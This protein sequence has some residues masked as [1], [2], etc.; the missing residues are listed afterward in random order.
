MAQNGSYK[1]LGPRPGSKYRQYF[2]KGRGVRAQTLYRATLEPDALTPEEVAADRDVPVEAVYEAIDY[3]QRN[4]DL[5]RQ[6]WEEEE[7]II[8]RNGWD[9]PP[10]SQRGRQAS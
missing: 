7:E 2:V 5:L 6:E 10:P 3:C 4:A 1:W 8:R 9:Q